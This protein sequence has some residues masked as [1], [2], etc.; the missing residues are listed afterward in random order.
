[1]GKKNKAKSGIVWELTLFLLK[2]DV[3]IWQDALPAE[4]R[5][6]PPR[7]QMVDGLGT[8]VVK[9]SKDKEPQWVTRLSQHWSIIAD[10]KQ[11]SPGA[12]LF[13]TAGKRMF[14]ATFG[15][16]RSL[17]SPDKLVHDFGIRCVLNSVNSERLRSLDLRTLETDPLSSRKQFGNGKPLA[18]FG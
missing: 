16:G 18:S 4:K 15:Y 17:L 10:Q 2:P 1:M 12:V 3:D 6:R 8:L 7:H 14:S 13:I 11:R 5:L 9:A